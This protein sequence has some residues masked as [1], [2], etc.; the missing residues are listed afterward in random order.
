MSLLGMMIDYTQKDEQAEKATFEAAM[1]QRIET[2]GYRMAD[3]MWELYKC[4]KDINTLAHA[5]EAL[6]APAKG[7]KR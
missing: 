7:K 2:Q 3:V 5:L 4:Q 6:K 1:T